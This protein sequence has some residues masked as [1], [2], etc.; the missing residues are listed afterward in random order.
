MVAVTL[1][2]ADLLTLYQFLLCIPL[3][4]PMEVAIPD[5]QP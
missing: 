2:S 5:L 3:M 4:G 1:T